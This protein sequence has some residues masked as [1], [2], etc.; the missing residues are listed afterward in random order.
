MEDWEIK[1]IDRDSKIKE[2]IRIEIWEYLYSVKIIK[3]W[4]IEIKE[5]NIEIAIEWINKVK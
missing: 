4:D 1:F 3:K 5:R 2:K